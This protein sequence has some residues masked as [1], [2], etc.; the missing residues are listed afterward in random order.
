MDSEHRH[1]LKENDLARALA[2]LGQ[3][4]KKHGRTTMVGVLVVL[5]VVAAWRMMN[6]RS[7]KTHEKTW[8][9]L[10]TTS[11]PDVFRTLAAT[12]S[13]SAARALANLWGAT[14]YNAQA[15]R[16]A[17]TDDPAANDRAAALEH[18]EAM[19]ANVIDDDQ[20]PKMMRLNALMAKAA[21]MENL[22]RFEEAQKLYNQVKQRADVPGYEAWGH[23]AQSR[24]DLLAQFHNPV[25]FGPEPV[26]TDP[27]SDTE[28]PAPA[29]DGTSGT[30][31][32][33]STS[34]PDDDPQTPAPSADDGE[35]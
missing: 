21:V 14:R 29:D 22:G 28:A 23:R 30:S 24:I 6:F 5:L 32:T 4:W 1:E 10:A 17:D 9:E 18:A 33:P 35:S 15:S 11:N 3:W 26:A 19:L 13:D 12:Y 27:K 20:A 25:V 34:T 2:G 31:T 7:Q 16:P 8:T